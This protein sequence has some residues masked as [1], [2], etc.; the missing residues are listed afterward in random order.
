VKTVL[1]AAFS[2]LKGL[3]MKLLV[4]GA[5]GATGRLVVDQALAAGH[6]VRALVR[7]PEKLAAAGPAL[8]VITGQATDPVHV[9]DAMAG[10]DAV[11]STLGAASG[12]VMTDAAR[13]II[14]GSAASGVRRVVV[15]SSYAVLRERL[16]RPAGLMS[17]LAMGALVKDKTAAEDLLR[18]SDLDWTIVHAV[19]LTNGPAT[20]SARV[21]P[22]RATLKMGDSIARA[23]VAAWLLTAAADE[24][25]SRR[26][27]AIAG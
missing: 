2:Y 13:A 14:A 12:S 6:H 23:D 1:A 16:S 4:L 5:T 20:G 7:P 22:G 11:I 10:V 24:S 19:R 21:V 18:S 8:E 25:A 27:I 3:L 15:L 17:R 26:A 9:G